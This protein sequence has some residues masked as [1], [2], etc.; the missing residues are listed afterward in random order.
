MTKILKN[1]I[2][3]FCSV[4]S[5]HGH[6]NGK[7][8]LGVYVDKD[9]KKQFEKDFNEVW[10]NGKTAKANKPAYK[11]K[12][13]FSKDEKT[14]ELI[15]WITGKAGK[16]RGIIFKNGKGCSF[17]PKE[18]GTIGTGSTIDVSYDIY[19]YNDNDYG[20]MV[21]RSIK[22]IALKKLIPYSDDGGVDGE[23]VEV[24]QSKSDDEDEKPVKKDKKDK[25]SKKDKKKKK[26]NKES[27]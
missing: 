22:A 19:Y 4:T 6:K 3:S 23:T 5:P 14:G 12:D 1:A 24:G 8:L 17:K 2:V 9:F 10:E 20:E 15:F 18:F 16:E 25:K 27:K 7:H 26:K 21:L 13:W 11:F